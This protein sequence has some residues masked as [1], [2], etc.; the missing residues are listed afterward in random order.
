MPPSAPGPAGSVPPAVPASGEG[1]ATGNAA[2][3]KRPTAAAAGPSLDS[4]DDAIDDDDGGGVPRWLAAK[5]TSPITG[6]VACFQP[7]AKTDAKKKKKKKKN[8][9][10][11]A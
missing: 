10:T 2:T 6:G 11:K 9:G 5:L 8:L 4:D 7:A 1:V 3:G